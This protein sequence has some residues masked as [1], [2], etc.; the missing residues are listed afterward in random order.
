[1]L[2]KEGLLVRHN[3]REELL[4]RYIGNLTFDSREIT[5]GTLFVCKGLRFKAEYL[6][7]ATA[8][9]LLKR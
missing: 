5:E 8:G 3:V 6:D 1:M 9:N 2:D 4:G 7:A